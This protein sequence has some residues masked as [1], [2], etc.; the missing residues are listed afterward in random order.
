MV[1]RFLARF[2]RGRLLCLLRQADLASLRRGY[3]RQ[4]R[5]LRNG[6][7]RVVRRLRGLRRRSL[8]LMLAS[9]YQAEQHYN[10]DLACGIHSLSPFTT[11]VFVSRS[12]RILASD[13]LAAG[14]HNVNV[15]PSPIFD[16]TA[17]CPWCS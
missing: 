7:R 10:R 17:S 12:P 6:A 11:D 1:S 15:D 4:R 8:R 13:M 2:W 16:S 9:G 3:L 14:T 5:I